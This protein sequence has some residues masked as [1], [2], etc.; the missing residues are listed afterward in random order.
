M[1]SSL[2]QLPAALTGALRRGRAAVVRPSEGADYLRERVAEWR[3]GRRGPWPYA[4]T[5]P[6]E[7]RVHDLA[8][9]RWPCQEGPQFEDVWASAVEDVA[10][11]GLQ[12]GRLSFGR[13]DD[14]DPRLGRL[15]W[16]LVR[17]LRPQVVVETGV[18]RGLT[19][20]TLLEGL[21]NNG[22][23]RLWSIDLPPFVDGRAQETAIAVP[24]RL[25]DRWTLLSGSSRKRLP[26]L[27]HTLGQ[28]DL[29]VHDSSHT[30]RNVRFELEQVWPALPPGG[31]VLIDDVEK[32]AATGEFIRAHPDARPVIG[33]SDD[34][35]VLIACII[36]SGSADY[37]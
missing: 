34:G 12:V 25:R 29:F 14:G 37:A 19:T 8:G 15:A 13:W 10:A 23:G 26:K 24:W 33:R 32:N 1:A 22:V 17:H 3:D 30:A 36:K 5:D 20:R 21:Q 2:A 31:A 7:E 18:A 27:L 28:V 16:C 35:D 4:I 11:A 9:G 6:F